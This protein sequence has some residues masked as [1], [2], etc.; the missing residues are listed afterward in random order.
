MPPGERSLPTPTGQMT[1]ENPWAAYRPPSCP[2]PDDGIGPVVGQSRPW[3]SDRNQAA[4]R[5][6]PATQ[7]LAVINSRFRYRRWTAPDP[8]PTFVSQACRRRITE[9][10]PLCSIVTPDNRGYR[11]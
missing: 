4:M 10:R 9:L 2:L 7:L 8:E 1:A 6:L 3:A 11:E 5:L